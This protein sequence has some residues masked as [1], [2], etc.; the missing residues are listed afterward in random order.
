MNEHVRDYAR[1]IH[2]ASGVPGEQAIDAAEATPGSALALGNNTPGGDVRGL[3]FAAPPPGPRK[4]RPFGMLAAMS[5]TRMVTAA[6][7]SRGG[8]GARERILTAATT[9]FHREGIHATGVERLTE[10]AHVSKR[11]FYQHFSS[12]NDLVEEYLRRIH[13]AG[14]APSEQAIDTTGASP[15]ARMLAVFDSAPRG[16]FRGCPF[17]NAA[18]EAA[19]AMPGVENIVHEHK[20]DFIARLIHTATEAGARDPYRLGNQLA[21]LFEGARALATS[22]NDTSPLLHARSAAETLI[23]AAT[24]DSGDWGHLVGGSD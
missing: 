4:G 6:P 23:D 5:G 21:V 17:H 13:Q 20:L 8:R 1:R 24:I 3:P 18:V 10:Q 15:R 12:K 14:G 19:D 9:L 16:R 11:T 2:K 22:L 7:A